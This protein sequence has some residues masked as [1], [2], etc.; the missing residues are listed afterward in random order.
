V[1]AGEV[2]N[3]AAVWSGE[4]TRRGAR[5]VGNIMEILVSVTAR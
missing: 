5:E 3:G 2:D 4:G 1:G